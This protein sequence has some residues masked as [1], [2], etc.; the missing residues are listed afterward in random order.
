MPQVLGLPVVTEASPLCRSESQVCVACC[1]GENLSREQFTRALLRQSRLFAVAFGSHAVLP[2]RVA[3]IAYEL[4]ARRGWPLLVAPFFLLP[5][6]GPLLR[7]WVARRVCCAFLGPVP[8]DAARPGCLL[9]P[10]R[11][12]GVDMRRRAAFALLPGMQCGE[13]GYVCQSSMLYR[14]AGPA[15]RRRLREQTRGMDWF[16]FSNLVRTAGSELVRRRVKLP[17][18]ATP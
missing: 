5:G 15:D 6:I 11:W 13:P 4:R 12:A 8:G 1:H 9:H 18:E 17:G 3:L 16:E 14:I 7:S 10:S 2:S